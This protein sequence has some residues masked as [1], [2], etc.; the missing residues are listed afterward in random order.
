MATGKA[1]TMTGV[2][3]SAVT[4]WSG[5]QSK[6]SVPGLCRLS[7]SRKV[8]VVSCWCF[9]AVIAIAC[10]P[11]AAEKRAQAAEKRAQF[12]DQCKP[13]APTEEQGWFDTKESR[14]NNLTNL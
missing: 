6:A 8:A 2:V 9:L 4:G 10:G 1:V 11:T 13:V 5:E 3:L 12:T 7:K 14:H